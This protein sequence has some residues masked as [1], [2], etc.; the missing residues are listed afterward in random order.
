MKK[1][2]IVVGSLRNASF[3]RMVANYLKVVL[4]KDY[5]VSLISVDNL[6]LYNEDIDHKDNA[7]TEYKE[8]R[9]LIK[10]Q[11]A[12]IFVTPEYNRGIPGALKNAIDVAS[13][14]YGESV[15]NNKKAAIISQSPG[16]IG[17]FGAATQLRPVLAVLNMPVMPTPEVYLSSIYLAFDKTGN[18]VDDKIKKILNDFIEA[19]KKFL[20]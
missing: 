20:E 3:S 6:P 15:W 11:E 18:L 2:G 17:G 5:I 1:I 4:D 14:P 16:S 8:F 12:F 9:K 19:Y 7:P 10:E 13:R